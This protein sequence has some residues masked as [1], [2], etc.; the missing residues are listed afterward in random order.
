M[1][2]AS[3]TFAAQLALALAP[4]GEGQDEVTVAPHVELAGTSLHFAHNDAACGICQARSLHGL[5][6]RTAVALPVVEVG[7]GSLVRARYDFVAAELESPSHSRAP[8]VAL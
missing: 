4:L 1:L 6:S 3:A 5:A 2:A 8:P 7:S